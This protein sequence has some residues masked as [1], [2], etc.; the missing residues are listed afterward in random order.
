[1][2]EKSAKLKLKIEKKMFTVDVSPECNT[3]TNY[4]SKQIKILF[5]NHVASAKTVMISIVVAALS[6][7]FELH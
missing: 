3:S 4:S 6:V 2:A 5:K 1:M 7:K